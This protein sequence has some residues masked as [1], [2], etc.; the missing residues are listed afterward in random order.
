MNGFNCICGHGRKHHIF[1]GWTGVVEQC[2]GRIKGTKK[3][4]ACKEMTYA[5]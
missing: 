3:R 2:T 4:C 5:K 1:I